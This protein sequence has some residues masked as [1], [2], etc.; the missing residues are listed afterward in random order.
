MGHPPDDV[1]V[2]PAAFGEFDDPLIAESNALFCCAIADSPDVVADLFAAPK[3][4]RPVRE[5]DENGQITGSSLFANMSSC[6]GGG[7]DYPPH[8]AD[9]AL[10]VEIAERA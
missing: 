8:S 9:P 6:V 4:F 1:V 5:R 2:R 3:A 10:G 7:N